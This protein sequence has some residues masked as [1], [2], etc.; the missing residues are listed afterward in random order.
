M[1]VASASLGSTRSGTPS[2]WFGLHLESAPKSV[3]TIDW[4]WVQ[5]FRYALVDAQRADELPAGMPTR[6]LCPAVFAPSVHL[7]PR[8]LDLRALTDTHWAWMVETLDRC[9][10]QQECPPLAALLHSNCEPDRMAQHLVAIQVHRYGDE[11]AWLRVH[12]PMVLLQLAR[13]TDSESMRTLFGPVQTWSL[14]LM[15]DWYDAYLATVADTRPRPR[16]SPT[17]CWRGLQ[18]IGSVN[19]ALLR[20]RWLT[21]PDILLHSEHLDRLVQRAERLH[22][23]QRPADLAAFADLGA[24]LAIEF[25]EHPLLRSAIQTWKA[26]RQAGGE[27][28]TTDSLIDELEQLPSTIWDQVHIDCALSP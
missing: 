10:A 9:I 15:G 27:S 24:E 11:T 22:A 1:S 6:P 12:D 23:L 16:R 5:Q 7:M 14:C 8:L 2:D 18:R 25:D 17:Q 20:R 26:W 3:H 19:R 4:T 21:L 28:D 13:A